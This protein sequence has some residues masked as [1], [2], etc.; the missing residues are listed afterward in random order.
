MQGEIGAPLLHQGQRL[1]QTLHRHQHRACGFR[2]VGVVTVERLRRFQPLEV[3]DVMD[4]VVIG[5]GQH[6]RARPAVGNRPGKGGATLRRVQ[7]HLVGNRV[8]S[9]GFQSGEHPVPQRFLKIDFDAELVGNGARH[10]NV[11]TGE[12]AALVVVIEGRIRAVGAND[13]GAV[14]VDTREQ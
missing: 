5:A 4:A 7:R 2:A 14:V 10:L 6:H 11:I 8:K 13:N 1:R 12:L 9:P 3:G